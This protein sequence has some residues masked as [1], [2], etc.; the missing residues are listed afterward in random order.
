M[1]IVLSLYIR[2]KLL[3]KWT[4]NSHI[5]SIGCINQQ[6]ISFKHRKDEHPSHQGA[7]R[8]ELGTFRSAVECS[9]TELYPHILYDIFVWPLIFIKNNCPLLIYWYFLKFDFFVSIFIFLCLDISR[10][11]LSVINA[12]LFHYTALIWSAIS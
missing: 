10:S 6:I 9:T 4:R 12:N 2:F 8:F 1:I 7:P 3:N 11:E 5:T